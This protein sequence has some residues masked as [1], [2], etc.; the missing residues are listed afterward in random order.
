MKTLSIAAALLTSTPMLGIAITHSADQHETLVESEDIKS[1]A[2]I[3]FLSSSDKKDNIEK[4]LERVVSYLKTEKIDQTITF[5]ELLPGALLIAKQYKTDP[6]EVMLRLYASGITHAQSWRNLE[7]PQTS[8]ALQK[9]I[10]DFEKHKINKD[11]LLPIL[12]D[13]PEHALNPILLKSILSHSSAN[14]LRFLVND[15]KRKHC[16]LTLIDTKSPLSHAFPLVDT[17]KAQILIEAFDLTTLLAAAGQTRLTK[18]SEPAKI[19]MRSSFEKPQEFLKLL[20]LFSQENMFAEMLNMQN[21]QGTTLLMKLIEYRDR[22]NESLAMQEALTLVRYLIDTSKIHHADANGETALIVAT[23]KNDLEIIK[24][25]LE[26]GAKPHHKNCCS[27]EA[28]DFTDNPSIKHLLVEWSSESNGIKSNNLQAPLS[29]TPPVVPKMSKNSKKRAAA[30]NL[31]STGLLTDGPSTGDTRNTEDDSALKDLEGHRQCDKETRLLEAVKQ[32]EYQRAVELAKLAK[33]GTPLLTAAAKGMTET[34]A[35]LLRAGAVTDKA[36]NNQETPL[37]K[38]AQNGNSMAVQA[39]LEAG[40]DVDKANTHGVTP[41]CIAAQEG[42]ASVIQ[43]LL[44]A[45]A[46]IDK[47]DHTGLPP[48]LRAASNGHAT[49]VLLLREAKPDRPKPVEP[50][51]MTGP[52]SFAKSIS[53]KPLES[54][55]EKSALFLAARDNQYALV[56]T[57]LNNKANPDE[58]APD[59]GLTPLIAAAR[60]GHAQIVKILIRA[61]ADCNRAGKNEITPLSM[62]VWEGK[63][64]VVKILLAADADT[65]QTCQGQTPLHIA[66]IR[67]DDALVTLLLDAKADKN[68]RNSYGE[69]PLIVAAGLGHLAVV[70]LLL[71]A[72]ADIHATHSNGATALH[73]AAEGG[74]VGVLRYLLAGGANINSVNKMGATSLYIAAQANKPDIVRIL[75]DSRSEVD[76]GNTVDGATPLLIATQQGHTAVVRMLLKAGADM[77]KRRTN[78]AATPLCIAARDGTIEIIKLFAQECGRSVANKR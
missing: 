78:D 48:L 67:G 29:G 39:L 76:R 32:A 35:I 51:A 73:V 72:Q 38:A 50:S 42:H 56:Q 20:I 75:L 24:L 3:Y 37:F 60:L 6:A 62:A 8:A 57:L 71:E 69:T 22:Y 34:I 68:K 21:D 11:L 53:P 13:E 41:V 17:E 63:E 4:T 65:E 47:T 7:T 64:S 12:M 36:D 74:H 44:N 31:P 25:L 43:M 40:A 77:N 70:K 19:L 23:K 52:R 26:K 46:D 33:K 45:N 5:D 27:I 9:I 58:A 1:N 49:V 16:M 15:S 2:L 54:K 61:G 30:K 28:F 55:L 66:T 59:D 14:V 18:K 10:A